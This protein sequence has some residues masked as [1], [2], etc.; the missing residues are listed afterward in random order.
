MDIDAE[1]GFREFVVHR[2]AGLL[3]T[4][5]LLTGD[6]GHAEDLV[7]T[8]LLKTYRHWNRIAAQ[9]E[10]IAY[11]RRVLVTTAT[12]WRRRL[13]ST[14]QV[15]D[16]VPEQAHYDRYPERSAAVIDA[17]HALP[18]RMRAVVV[19][20]FYEDLTEAQTAELLGCSVGT[21]KTQSS[22][23]MT[24]LRSALAADPALRP[25]GGVA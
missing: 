15:M 24:R 3:R 13:L 25:T 19:L 23:A 22:R 12:S 21:V 1:A 2:R 5:Y 16:A 20:R 7:Q 8:A 14:E 10:P 6:D 17:L 4:A 9:G 18:P 11:V